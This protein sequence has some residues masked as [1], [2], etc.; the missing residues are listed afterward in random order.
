MLLVFFVSLDLLHWSLIFVFFAVAINVHFFPY[1]V[2]ISQLNLVKNIQTLVSSVTFEE[3]AF[4]IAI[5]ISGIKVI[6]SRKK[7]AQLVQKK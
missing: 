2:S 3:A 6:D 1:P 7:Y 5:L 4:L